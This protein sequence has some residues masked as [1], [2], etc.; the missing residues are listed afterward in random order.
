MF[1]LS[2]ILGCT[3]PGESTIQKTIGHDVSEV[4]KVSDTLPV[5]FWNK[6]PQRQGGWKYSPDVRV[7]KT[8][9]VS[10]SRIEKSLDFWRD[11]GY[12]FGRVY[13]NDISEHCIQGTFSYNTII[14]DLIDGTHREPALATTTTWIDQET[15]GI[16]K[17][18]IVLKNQWANVERVLEHEFGHALGWLDYNQ[19][20]HI[21]HHEWSRG[22][23]N[24]TG[25][26][27]Q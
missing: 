8:A 9:P 26:E 17:A 24:T 5:A 2:L 16:R 21:M 19:T 20:G 12:I 6:G 4:H 23:L 13:F 1:F 10:A 7:C 11:L 27:A 14:V 22:G 18:K 25:V 15:R 3:A